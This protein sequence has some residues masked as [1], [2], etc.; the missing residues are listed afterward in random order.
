MPWRAAPVRGPSLGR[1]A[2]ARLSGRTR[3]GSCGRTARQGCRRRAPR[4]GQRA[5]RPGTAAP[6]RRHP[7]AWAGADADSP[8]RIRTW[9]YRPG[10]PARRYR[11]RTSSACRPPAASQRALRC[12]S[13]G[14][15]RAISSSP[16]WRSGRQRR[17]TS[18]GACSRTAADVPRTYQARPRRLA[19][20]PQALH[21][22]FRR[23]SGCRPGRQRRQSA[24]CR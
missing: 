15:A 14:A 5:R 23:P 13:P 10:L 11:A 19:A 16:R 1:C 18:C 24:S 2:A 20:L 17:S 6:S 22:C 3:R 8:L 9:R 7:P 12:H 21:H 4:P